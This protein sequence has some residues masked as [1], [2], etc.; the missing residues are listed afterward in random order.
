M[1]KITDVRHGEMVSPVPF[2]QAYSRSS[3]YS[4]GAANWTV[5]YK[6]HRTA[7][8]STSSFAACL[9]PQEWDGRVISEAHV[10]V[11]CDASDPAGDGEAGDGSVPASVQVSQRINQLCSTAM[12]T[13]RQ[14]GRVLLIGEPYGVTQD[15]LQLV[16]ENVASLNLPLPQVIVVS[17][18][19]E[20]TLQY[21]N[22]MGE[23]LC[24]AKQA[25][26]YLPEYPFSD[27]DLRQKGH[28]HF[29]RALSDL[30]T[31]QVPQGSWFVVVSPQDVP[32]IDHF[33]RLWERD[34]RN[35][36]GS[37]AATASGAARFSVLL[38][39]DDVAWAQA[40]VRRLSVGPELTYVPVSCRLTLHSIE[41][42][43]AGAECAQQVLVPSPIFARL[44]PA[45]AAGSCGIPRSLAASGLDFR[46]FE[47][48]YLQ[49][50]TVHLDTDR[51]LPL[52]IQKEMAL[53]LRASGKQHAL[54]S[55]TLSFAAGKIRLA[56]DDLLPTN[57]Q[58]QGQGQDQGQL[59]EK[60]GPAALVDTS[61][62]APNVIGAAAADLALWTPHRLATELNDIGVNAAVVDGV[63]VRIV[64]PGGSAT[65]HMHRGWAIDCTSPAS[66]WTVM[67]SLRQVLN[68]A[69]P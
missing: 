2:V 25:L 49:A 62:G 46:L 9:H 36:S 59:V 23:W 26:L 32:A 24:E 61:D 21:G 13:L 69:H 51:H 19:G 33:I 30:A 57:A 20:R 50:A 42:C 52:S 17:P 10:I 48:S 66:Q 34:A 8:V 7:F 38:H 18:V 1:E 14:R 3:G 27:K 22:I 55:G 67:D 68:L 37:D 43:L 12:A 39:S 6:G 29:V 58:G 56:R 15:I 16:A 53:Q 11:I 54:V 44:A 45:D 40:L 28:L 4:I 64:M 63:G 31:L 65:V 35:C 5:E 47:Y 60:R 41:Q